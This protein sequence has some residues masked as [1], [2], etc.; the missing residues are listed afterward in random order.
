[1]V[2][3]VV[4]WLRLDSCVPGARIPTYQTLSASSFAAS[5]IALEIYPIVAVWLFALCLD[6]YTARTREVVPCDTRKI[7]DARLVTELHNVI[8]T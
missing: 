7:V 1:M 2:A 4:I 3:C 6:R 5:A 8:F